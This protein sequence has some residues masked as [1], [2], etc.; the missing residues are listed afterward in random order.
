MSIYPHYLAHFNE[1]VG[2]PRNGYRYLVDSNL[3]W[4][5]DDDLALAVARDS[6]EPMHVN[7]GC[8]RVSGLILVSATRF[9]GIFEKDVPCYD[10]LRALEPIGTVGYSYLQFRR[11]P[12]AI[13][14]PPR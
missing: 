7:P 3:D 5:Q 10:W 1:A 8:D 9:Q 13:E 12:T 6:P 11:P 14:G 4:G 2:G